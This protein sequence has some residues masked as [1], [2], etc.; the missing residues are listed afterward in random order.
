MKYGCL[1]VCRMGLTP[2]NHAKQNVQAVR[3]QSKQNQELKIQQEQISALKRVTPPKAKPATP[4]SRQ[5]VNAVQI[6]L[7]P[8]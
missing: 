7:G 1:V 4:S 6:A 3:Q 5:V 2:V 8:E